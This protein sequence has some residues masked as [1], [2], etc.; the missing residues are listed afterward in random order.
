LAQDREGIR[1]T[2]TGEG[3]ASYD[4]RSGIDHAAALFR[5]SGDAVFI[6]DLD[7]VI[8]DTNAEAEHLYG[9]PRE[10][11]HGRPLRV[12]IPERR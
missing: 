3:A 8:V 6:A 11:I 2:G 4:G 1:R 12:I 10:D 7:G 9:W 5:Q